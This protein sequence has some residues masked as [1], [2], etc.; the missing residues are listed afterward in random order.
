MRVYVII[1]MPIGARATSR[2]GK[3]VQI[4]MTKNEVIEAM[5][6]GAYVHM[7][8]IYRR[9][10]VVI[11]DEWH[12][13]RYD[14]AERMKRDKA[15]YTADHRSGWAFSTFI[16]ANAY[17]E[18]HADVFG[19]VME[20]DH[21]DGSTSVVV[22]EFDNENAL[23]CYC[24]RIYCFDDF[25]DTRRITRIVCRGRECYYVGWRPMMEFTYR[26]SD[27]HAHAWT[28][29]FDNWEH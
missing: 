20:V 23:F 6:N 7:D 26:Y 24:S 2:H 16:T 8:E 17:N 13:M 9:A 1:C 19:V 5:M 28:G 15:N 11:D 12:V 10:H 25:D 21:Y 14:V 4:M 3:K 18:A 22:K 27:T 29:Y